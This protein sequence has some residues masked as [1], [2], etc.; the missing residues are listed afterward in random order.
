VYFVN[1]QSK[2]RLKK[3]NKIG[4]CC[5]YACQMRLDI[6]AFESWHWCFRRLV[7]FFNLFLYFRKKKKG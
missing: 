7:I 3:H 2:L 1:Q 6:E 4:L 5:K